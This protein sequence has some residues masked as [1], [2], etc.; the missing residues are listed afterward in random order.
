LIAA[1]LAASGWNRTRAARKLGID[2][3]T[4]W[5][6]IKDHGLMPP[7]E[8]GGRGGLM[9]AGRNWLLGCGIG[10]GVVLLVFVLVAAGPSTC[11]ATPSRLQAAGG[12]Q[13]T[14]VKEHGQISDFRPR[15][16]GR[17][18]AERIVA[19]L[20][21]RDTTAAQRDELARA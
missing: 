11:S 14:L 18:P 21:V 5:R 16:D 4:L 9:S 2:R 17:I 6:K 3:S 15:P 7:S 20:A 12:I 1:A 19:F 8:R 10:C 13:T